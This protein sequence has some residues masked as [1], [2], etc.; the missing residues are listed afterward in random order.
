MIRLGSTGGGRS[1]SNIGVTSAITRS[2]PGAQQVPR[3][4]GQREGYLV[5]ALRK[6][7]NNTRRGYD[8]AIAEVLYES[9][10]EQLLDLAY[11]LARFQ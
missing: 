5:K 3:L 8:P 9:S 6:Y 10:D 11:F 7:E 2:F 4:A 1:F